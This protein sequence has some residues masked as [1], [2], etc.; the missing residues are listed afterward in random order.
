MRKWKYALVMV[1]G[2]SIYLTVQCLIRDNI[3]TAVITTSLAIVGGVAIWMEMQSNERIN[4]AQLIMELNNQFITN[5]NFADIEWAL[6]KYYAEYMQAKRNGKDP[7]ELTLDI[8]LSLENRNRQ[9]LVNYLVHLEGVAA[10]VNEGV[11]HLDVITDLMAYRYFIAVNNPDV[12]KAELL[13][14]KDYYNGIFRSTKNGARNWE[15]KRFPWLS[16]IC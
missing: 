10:L 11:L 3:V 5:E 9:K 2:I 8:D 6:E 16:S 13:P 14:Y 12:Q 1:F 7:A 15:M 4:E